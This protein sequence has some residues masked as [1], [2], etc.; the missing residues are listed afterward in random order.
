MLMTTLVAVLGFGPTAAIPMTFDVDGVKRTAMVFTPRKTDKLPPLLIA[1]HGHGGNGAGFANGTKFPIDWPEAIEVFPNGL[2]SVTKRDSEGKKP[3]WQD[4]SGEAGDRDVKLFDAILS[5]FYG[6]YD[7]SK[8]YVAGFSNGARFTYLLWS[9]RSKEIRAIAASAGNSTPDLNSTLSP[10]PAAIMHGKNDQ[11]CVEATGTAD[12][13]AILKADKANG[14]FT[15]WPAG[16]VEK[17]Y[18]H[19]PGGAPA[20]L[21]SHQGPHEW[22]A[23]ATP[24]VVKFFQNH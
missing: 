21:I 2:P 5:H 8:V 6:K 7:P 22:P 14:A 16:T 15:P 11:L 23:F 17:L 19:N 12:F 4:T 24:R 18:P 1:F 3:G 10:K 20:L 13:Q 9:V